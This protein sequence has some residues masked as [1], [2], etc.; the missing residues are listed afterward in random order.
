MTSQIG[1][2]KRIAKNTFVLYVRM[3]FL[4][5]ISLYTSRVILQALGVE[6]YGVYTAVGGFV[7]MFS[8]VSSSLSS[9]ASRFLNYE[10]GKGENA[11]LNKVFS[12]ILIIHVVLAILIAILTE[13]VGIWFVN[14][15]MIIPPDRLRAANFVFQFSLLTFCL[16]LMTVPYNATIIAH[17]Q[18]KIYAFI[19]IFEGIAKLL[20][21]YLLM[22][23]PFDRLIFYS[24]LVFLIQFIIRVVYHIYCK[25]HYPETSFRFV[26]D[27][28]ILKDI[29]GFV[30][31]NT[32]GASAAVLRNYGGNVLLNLFGGPVVNAARGVANQVL[33]AISAFVTN[34]MTAINPQITKSYASGDRSYMMM[35]VHRGARFSYYLLLVLSL[36]ILLN[37]DYILHVWL[38]TVPEHSVV[39]VQLSLIFNMIEVISNP[40]GTV[41]M[42]TGRIRTYQIIVGG[43]TLLN[44]PISYLFLRLGYAP[45]VVYVVAISLSICV[46]VARL[47]L[48]KNMISLDVIDF[49][50]KVVL[51]IM[52]VT[53]VSVPIP[54]V[55]SIY[56]NNSFSSF[57]W[58]TL[59]SLL[60]SMASVYYIGLS[61]GERSFVLSSIKRVIKRK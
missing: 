29:F 53:I 38:K 55:L 33:H 7:A 61:T 31:W 54:F 36:P 56:L 18:M 47:L 4:M 11:N 14:H 41:Q 25:R 30:G 34:F 6:D 43:L 59:L 51:D 24:F 17:E 58:I 35:L 27:K 49:L 5:A 13:G 1:N 26:Y 22:V 20:I 57:C 15:K 3:L 60:F 8:A 42:A 9:A 21:C 52:I 45:S 28:N 37:T 23:T 40:L 46:L 2:T 12:T 39:F 19:G 50:K 32:I 16:N 10:M 44:L 48:L